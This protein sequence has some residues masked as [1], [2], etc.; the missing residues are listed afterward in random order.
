[1]KIEPDRSGFGNHAFAVFNG[2][3]F[4]ACAGPALG[5]Q[6]EVQYV[7]DTIDVSRGRP[8]TTSNISSQAVIGLK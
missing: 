2:Y 5:T 8:G 3:V 1:M 6:T 4:N 7:S